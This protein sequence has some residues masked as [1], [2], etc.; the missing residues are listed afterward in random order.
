MVL[1]HDAFLWGSR[2]FPLDEMT[3]MERGLAKAVEAGLGPEV[4]SV[5]AN[6][7]NGAAYS[8]E[9]IIAKYC[10]LLGTN[11]TAVVAYEDRIA[12]NYLRARPDVIADQVGCIGLSGGGLRAAVL[13]ATSDHFRACAIVGMM[14]TYDELIELLRRSPH[15]D[16]FSRR[17][18]RP[19]RLARSCGVPRASA[20]ARSVCVGRRVVHARRHARRR[21]ADLRS[22]PG[23]GRGGFYIAANS[24]P[25]PTASMRRC[26]TM[27]LH[28]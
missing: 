13:R 24:T 18:E 11:I 26:R 23:G 7:Y 20:I 3:D 19:W 12:L 1:A 2:K 4:S 25:D 14:S 15:L 16:A 10:T 8:H 6:H 22:L 5:A 27:P 17:L 28:G 21:Q 9:H